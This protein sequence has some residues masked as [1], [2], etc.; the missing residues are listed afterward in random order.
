M[1]AKPDRYEEFLSLVGSEKTRP[2]V[3]EE[4]FQESLLK[5]RVDGQKVIGYPSEI[6]TLIS[7]LV[8]EKKFTD[9]GWRECWSYAHESD[10]IFELNL[11]VYRTGE[12]NKL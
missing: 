4:K 6:P 9:E 11:W 7:H 3:S 1:S 2:K 8:G 12:E 10:D 5:W